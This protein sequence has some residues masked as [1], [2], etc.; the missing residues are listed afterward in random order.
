MRNYTPKHFIAQE[1]LPKAIYG[2]Y[3][4]SG[5]SIFMDARILWTADQIREHYEVPCLINDWHRG[6]LRGQC[7]YR[8]R[9][10]V[11]DSSQCSQHYF[12]R[13]IDMIVMGIKSEQVRQDIRDGKLIKEITYVTRIEDDVEWLHL[14][15][16][17]VPG[18]SIIFIHRR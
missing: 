4:D 2:M 9:G 16:A 18:N 5:L 8:E 6:G 10:V 15:C 3:G 17:S 11:I 14:D 7:G 1:F 12:G 13:A